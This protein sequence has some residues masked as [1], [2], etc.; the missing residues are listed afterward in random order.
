MIELMRRYAYGFVNSHDFAVPR[1]IMSEDYTLHVGTATLV[2]RDESYLP[3]VQ[4]QMDQFPQLGYS[5]HELITD[6]DQTAV[7]FSE[8]G[9]SARMP[10]REASWIGVG[11]YRVAEGRLVECW[12]EQDHYGKRRQLSSAVSNQVPLVATDPWSGHEDANPAA[13]QAAELIVR[14]WLDGLETWPPAD[15]RLDPGFADA[16]QPR[17]RITETELITIVAE[18]SRVAFNARIVGGYEGGLP[19]YDGQ[20]GLPVET[21]VCAIGDATDGAV[22]GLR[23]ASNRVAID[24]QLRTAGEDEEQS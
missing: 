22:T 15:S 11:I 4:Q 17:I 7:L 23:G 20:I 14:A 12:V 13:S 21:W 5:I 9:R 6:Q 18:G 24:R 2:G 1:E 10:D 3:A 8:H 16:E 19:G